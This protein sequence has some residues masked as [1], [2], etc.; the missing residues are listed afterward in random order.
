MKKNLFFLLVIWAFG[1]QCACADDLYNRLTASDEVQ[2]GQEY[3][4]VS[5]DRKGMMTFSDNTFGNMSTGYDWYAADT[6]IIVPFD[7]S[8]RPALLALMAVG[9]RFVVYFVGTEMCLYATGSKNNSPKLTTRQYDDYFADEPRAQWKAEEK[10]G[11]VVL[12]NVSVDLCIVFANQTYKLAT[13]NSGN[14]YAHLY[15]KD[16]EGVLVPSSEYLSYVTLTDVDFT[17]TEGLSAFQATYATKLGVLLSP[18]DGAPAHTAVVLHGAQGTYPIRDASQPVEP[19][20]GNL[21]RAS[22]G[23]RSHRADGSTFYMLDDKLSN[24]V[25]FYLMKKDDIVP[26]R[27]GYLIISEQ[28]DGRAFIPLTDHQPAAIDSVPHS[29]RTPGITP[30]YDLSGRRIHGPFPKGIVIASGSK[31]AVK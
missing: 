5:G 18:I 10:D 25:G 27:S 21:L 15:R 14:S 7:E 30:G 29:P 31:Y 9:D 1:L 17:Q 28:N 16:G 11:G 26:M 22:D 23:S 19:L 2:V 4:L 12:R 20:T 24:G 6:G 13:K 3:I 8:Q